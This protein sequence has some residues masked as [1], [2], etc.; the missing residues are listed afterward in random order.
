[1]LIS[2]EAEQKEGLRLGTRLENVSVGVRV[3][4]EQPES[5]FIPQ[6]CLISLLQFL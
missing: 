4:V 2:K 3:P 5:G 6:V 1:M